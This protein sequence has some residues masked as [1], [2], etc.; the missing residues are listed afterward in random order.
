MLQ[1]SRILSRVLESPPEIPERRPISLGHV[2]KKAG[3][4]SIFFPSMSLKKKRKKIKK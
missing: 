1:P 3:L 4:I 2:C